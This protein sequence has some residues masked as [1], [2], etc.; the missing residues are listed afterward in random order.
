MRLLTQ[1]SDGTSGTALATIYLSYN[2][3]SGKNCVVTVNK[4]SSSRWMRAS[5]SVQGGS[6]ASD[7]GT[8]HSYAGPVILSA[9]DRCVKWGGTWDE[10][11]F[12]WTSGWSHCG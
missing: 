7:S 4:T 9:I 12:T 1:R 5:L 6:T 11:P 3:S 10:S 2:A 8:F